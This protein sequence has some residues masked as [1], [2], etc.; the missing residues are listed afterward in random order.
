MRLR[1]KTFF[2]YIAIIFII[3]PIPVYLIHTKIQHQ[4]N[5]ILNESKL[6]SQQFAHSAS[7]I[8]LLNGGNIV[9]TS[10]DAEKYFKVYEPL[11]ATGLLSLQVILSTPNKKYNGLLL[12]DIPGNKTL[13]R[14]PHTA[15][16][17][18]TSA[19]TH[20]YTYSD[21]MKHLE[22]IA[23]SP[24]SAGNIYCIARFLYNEDYLL[25][26]VYQ[27]YTILFVSVV[28][29]LAVSLSLS[30]ALSYSFSKPL[31]RIIQSIKMFDDGISNIDVPSQNR[32][33]EIGKLATTVQH[34]FYMVN[35]EISALHKSNRELKR[36]HDVKDDFL[37]NLSNEIRMP[38]ESIIHLAHSV[39]HDFTL[40]RYPASINSLQYIA[41][42]ALRLSY[43]ID[44]I[45]DFTRLKNNDI[46]LNKKVTDTAGVINFIVSLLQP[47]ILTKEL[48]I[49]ISVDDDA[50]RIYADEQRIQQILLNIISNAVNYTQQ[51]AISIRAQR[52]NPSTVS[53]SVQD[54]GSGIPAEILNS[55]DD[56]GYDSF[57]TDRK[58]SGLGLGLV[59]SKK[60]I[61]LH[62]GSITIESMPHEGSTV[63]ISLPSSLEALNDS[64]IASP[65]PN[66]SS[67]PAEHAIQQPLDSLASME[68]SQGFV[69]II[70]GNPVNAKV[71]SDLLRNAGFYVESSPNPLLLYE[72][73]RK[74]R[75]PD[76]VLLDTILYGTS[77]FEVCE[78]IRKSHSQY[79]LPIMI[80]TSKHRTQEIITGFRVGANDYLSKPYH[81]DELTAR[82]VNLITL[83]KSLQQ[84]TEYVMLKHEIQLAHEIHNSVVVQDIPELHNINIAH[85]YIPTRGMGGD[86]YDVIAI[87]STT[88]GIIIADVTGHGIPAALVG[89]ML[90]MAFVNNNIHA[91]HPAKMLTALNQN[92]CSNIQDNYITA[93]YAVIDT[94]TKTIT[95]SS[96][97]HWPPLL[98]SK[99]GSITAAI[100][101][102]FPIGW[103]D[104][105]EYQEIQISYRPHDKLILYTDGIID[106]KNDDRQIFGL[107]RLMEYIHMHYDT[108]PDFLVANLIKLLHTWNAFTDT[109]TF[110]D[111]LTIIIAELL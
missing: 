102:A 3:T 88:A 66:Y 105:L 110:P 39:I 69:Y 29:I 62:D 101:K 13:T 49:S 33:D 28:L 94:N 26:P 70:D 83:K 76:V 103:V 19:R 91:R 73:I 12:V 85:A 5:S 4:K 7:N 109:E 65:V 9:Q 38:L 11:Y 22:F 63:S 108:K 27:N 78:T 86:F 81:K 54:T 92:L 89:S 64:S 8:L 20:Y 21:N 30:F 95:A 23:R 31:E 97:G 82:I 68:A 50:A 106:V 56:F 48:S 24:I 72:M 42:S 58:Y 104:S 87:D 59:I 36:L 10:V 32:G 100:P 80:I 15:V 6:L 41:N 52:K 2:T 43:I 107:Q 111:D 67:F 35:L 90:K 18:L 55:I 75:L 47:A 1:Y 17:R 96:A 51:G 98:I 45:L 37:E 61:Q 93:L 99:Q 44:D 14:L 84:H 40:Q 53:I 34:L 79:D 25:K 77:A 57:L 74:E 71:L 16:E 46:V 60:L